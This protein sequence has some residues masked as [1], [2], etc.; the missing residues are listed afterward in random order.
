MRGSSG[1]WQGRIIT[2]SEDIAGRGMDTFVTL[3]VGMVSGY[4][5]LKTDQIV[6]FTQVQYIVCQLHLIKAEKNVFFNH[7]MSFIF[8]GEKKGPDKRQVRG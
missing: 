7:K 6:Y 1:G 5:C 2:G 3:I 8:G 4:S